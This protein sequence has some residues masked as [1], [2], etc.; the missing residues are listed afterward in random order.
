MLP[1]YWNHLENF[2]NKILLPGSHSQRYKV[3]DF[4]VGI[5]LYRMLPWGF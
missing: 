4:R 1:A 5:E 3:I 2:K